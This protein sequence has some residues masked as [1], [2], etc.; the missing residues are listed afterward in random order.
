MTN[1][2]QKTIY[3]DGSC[4]LCT[5]EIG[6]YRQQSGAESLCF[7]DISHDK[8]VTGPGLTQD[9][10]MARFHVR[11]RDGSLLSGAAAFVSVWDELPKWRWA[12]RLAR[13]PGVLPLLELG[14]RGFLPLRPGLAALMRRLG[15]R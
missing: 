13:L 2:D 14:Y 3:Y 6:H 8:S 1:A 5:L 7:I 12:A 4:P 15:R 10:A 11:A 9:A